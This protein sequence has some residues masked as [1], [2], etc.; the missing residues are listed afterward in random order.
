MWSKGRYSHM[1]EFVREAK[2]FGFTQVELNSI[3]TP[4]KLQELLGVGGLKV[5]SIHCPCPVSLS[6][7]GIWAADLSLSSLD[8]EERREAI[9]FAKE[10]IK[11]AARLGVKAVVIH[12][13]RVELDFSLEEKLHKLYNQGLTESKEYSETKQELISARNSR[14]GLYLEAARE[15]LKE[16]AEFAGEEGVVLGLE[17]RVYFYEIPA[18]REMQLLLA[19]LPPELVGFWYDIGH[20]EVQSRLGFTP[21]QEW[22]SHFSKRVVGV[23]LHDVLG[24]R[25]HRAPGTGDVDWDFLAQNLPRNIIKVCEIGEWNEREACRRAVP[26]LKEKGIIS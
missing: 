10:T 4:E 1:A 2:E 20:A 17:N 25:D 8:K 7:R 16:L 6:P 12:S 15:S 18:L 23:H 26:F 13:G 14:A 19:E 3:L 22:L 24:I 11:L 9:W 21:W 5:S